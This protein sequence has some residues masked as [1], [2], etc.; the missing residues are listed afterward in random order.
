MKLTRHILFAAIFLSLLVSCSKQESADV[1]YKNGQIYTVDENQPWVEAVAIK[2]GKFIAVGTNAEVDALRGTATEVIDLEGEFVMPGI[3]DTHVH[4]PLV[5]VF[6]ESGDLLFPESLSK[7][8]VQEVL[9]KYAEDHPEKTK[10]RG[11]KWATTL[12][13]GGK[14]TKTFLDEVISDIPVLLLDETGH[15]AVANSKALE[16]A[17]ITKDTPNPEGGKFDKEPNTGEPTGYLS[18]TAIGFLNSK[19]F[20]RP[21]LDAH[22]RGM[23]QAL[24][25]MR[26]YGITSFIDMGV[27]ENALKTYVQLEKEKKLGFRVSTSIHMAHFSGDVITTKEAVE[28]L[29]RRD[30][31]DTHLIN[32]H[33]VKYFGDGTPF[34]YTSLLLEPYS[35]KPETHGEMALLKSSFDRLPGL[36]QQ[37]LAIRFH[38]VTDGTTRKLLDAIEKLRQDNPD[39]LVRHHIGH[40]MTVHPDDIQRFKKLNVIAEFSP[41]NWYPHALNHTAKNYVGEERV[42]RWQPIKE[43]VDAG[44]SVSYGSDWPAGTPNADPWR[45]LEGMVT[46]EDPTGQMPGKLGEGIDLATGIYILTIGGAYAMQ[47]EDKVGSIEEGKYAD[48]IVLDRNLFEIP[49]K[50]IHKTKALRTVFEGEVIYEAD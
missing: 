22:Y 10:I 5:Y 45:A 26:A 27:G 50:D 19:V 41:A 37:G 2:D 39:N 14:A 34:S 46:R 35:D 1:I 15:N 49:V 40:L 48:F 6:K 36:D 43:F 29:T 7:E 12:F 11:E 8:E 38:S 33:G 28:L 18:E 20:E 32:P 44:A 24:E 13:P 42:K 23:S 4:P 30:Q 47:H 3:H 21:D 25:E 9:R 16:L 17:G 31:F